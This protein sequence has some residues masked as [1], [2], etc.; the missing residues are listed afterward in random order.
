M[1]KGFLV[2]SG[3]V[4]H[5]YMRVATINALSLRLARYGR[6]SCSHVACNL[7]AFLPL[8]GRSHCPVCVAVN[9]SL[10]IRIE[11]LI[12]RV[13]S[14]HQATTNREV[15]VSSSSSHFCVMFSEC[16]LFGQ[17]LSIFLFH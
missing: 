7:T 13:Q 4:I 11:I 8:K 2:T 5:T 1:V 6:I 12:P 16:N 17:F 14:E 3:E 15:R 9:K 10:L